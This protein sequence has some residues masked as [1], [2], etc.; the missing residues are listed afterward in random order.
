MYRGYKPSQHSTYPNDIKF[1]AVTESIE[2]GKLEVLRT[3]EEHQNKHGELAVKSS[4]VA[5]LEVE[6]KLLS[7]RK[8]IL[9][10]Q[11]DSLLRNKQQLIEKLVSSITV[12]CL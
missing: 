2:Q 5:D 8:G 3:R 7:L 10:E 1:C 6:V 11:R 4:K 12:L 9:Q